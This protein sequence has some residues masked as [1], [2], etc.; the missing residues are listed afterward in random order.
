[1]SS[2]IESYQNESGILN[3]GVTRVLDAL[4]AVKQFQ[5]AEDVRMYEPCYQKLFSPFNECFNRNRNFK[6]FLNITVNVRVF[7]VLR[8]LQLIFCF[9]GFRSWVLECKSS[10][11]QISVFT[12]FKISFSWCFKLGLLKYLLFICWFFYVL[13]HIHYF[14]ILHQFWERW[15][16]LKTELD[17]AYWDNL[18]QLHPKRILLLFKHCQV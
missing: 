15:K 14:T 4:V 3:S 8:N 1:M 16:F 2:G 6:D 17:S 13:L 10:A 12:N 11:K 7:K 5:L 18:C 9:T